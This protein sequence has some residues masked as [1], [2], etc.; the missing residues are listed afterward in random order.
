MNL[1]M[2]SAPNITLLISSPLA[3][4]VVESA[5][6]CLGSDGLLDF[7]HL[8][9]PLEDAVLSQLSADLLET[10]LYKD[11]Q[12]LVTFST[13]PLS[14]MQHPSG[15]WSQC[16][17]SV[18][19]AA[20][21]LEL[22]AF[23]QQLLEHRAVLLSAPSF[24]VHSFQRLLS[25][26]IIETDVTTDKWKADRSSLLELLLESE[27]DQYRPHLRALV[28]ILDEDEE[29]EEEQVVLT[30]DPS[31]VV[32]YEEGV[33]SWVVS[34]NTFSSKV[35]TA[36]NCMLIAVPKSLQHNENL[37]AYR[38]IIGK[39]SHSSAIV[40]LEGITQSQSVYLRCVDSITGMEV[41]CSRLLDQSMFLSSC[42]IDALVA[43][44]NYLLLCDR[45]PSNM[46][47]SSS[48]DIVAA[49]VPTVIGSFTTMKKSAMPEKIDD[50]TSSQ[51]DPFRL[52]VVGRGTG[53]G[54]SFNDFTRELHSQWEEVCHSLTQVLNSPW[55]GVDI[56]VH[57]GSSVDWVQLLRDTAP[58]LNAA[59]GA[60]ALH[61]N[62]SQNLIEVE[63]CVAEA[64]QSSF[65]LD[66]ARTMF[67][68]G[69]HL[70]L[71][72][73]VRELLSH[74]MTHV[75]RGDLTGYGQKILCQLV[76]KHYDLYRQAM[77]PEMMR[78]NASCSLLYC[79]GGICVV[80][81]FRNLM[82]P[83]EPLDLKSVIPSDAKSLLLLLSFPV[84]G[85]G[86]TSW[87]LTDH[88]LLHE[89]QIILDACSDW[90]LS[91]PA[92]SRE[93]LL[94]AS[95]GRGEIVSEITLVHRGKEGSDVLCAIK[96]LSVGSLL[97]PNPRGLAP[98]SRVSSYRVDCAYEC[99]HIVLKDKN[100]LVSV[101][102][103]EIGSMSPHVAFTSVSVDQLRDYREDM[104]SREVRDFVRLQN[105]S[106]LALM[107]LVDGALGDGSYV[108]EH[109]G[110]FPVL[111]SKVAELSKAFDV[112]FTLEIKESIL[113]LIRKWD[114]GEGSISV[115]LCT[116]VQYYLLLFM[117]CIQVVP[118]S[119][120]RFLRQPSALAIRASWSLMHRNMPSSERV[121]KVL[122]SQE[123]KVLEFFLFVQLWQL[124]LSYLCD[125]QIDS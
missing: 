45:Q 37:T 120:K 16:G 35:G 107:R 39:V 32:R 9:T 118:A 34:Y 88:E 55:S 92:A 22:L 38:A 1:I 42:R 89:E 109:D 85:A 112:I 17:L 62:P 20:K 111:L 102:M 68:H 83:L 84:L 51:L 79:I 66:S 73:P 117:A 70:L 52:F 54:K 2:K 56:V 26:R 60:L 96:Q 106:V 53:D 95:G 82:Q 31:N 13:V 4:M 10:S 114:S 27:E 99:K 6:N 77:W 63:K 72:D 30:F 75:S 101:I 36:Q 81:L 44:R 100:P 21:M 24:E 14:G 61:G 29:E 49:K 103:I 119:Y 43:N 105:S 91:N 98:E 86:V 8:Q 104:L 3:L 11:V 113:E 18:A 5:W 64:F 41:H 57:M 48:N 123:T 116:P 94:L 78:V 50:G 15:I 67:A 47:F 71:S 12:F 19:D 93:V 110:S 59:E 76:Q 97:A 108:G 122:Q 121:V 115:A 40:V 33:T 74:H 25:P 80:H 28:S 46:M 69:C 23:W 58:L 7:S 125:E 87:P 90:V 65:G 124:S